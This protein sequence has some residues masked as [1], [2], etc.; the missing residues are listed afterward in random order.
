MSFIRGSSGLPVCTPSPRSPNQALV[1]LLQISLIRGS[2]LLVVTALPVM[3]T[4]SW[5]LLFWKVMV[6]ASGCFSM[7]LNCQR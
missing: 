1:P 2:S 5:L 7:S 3:E 6:T 4:Q